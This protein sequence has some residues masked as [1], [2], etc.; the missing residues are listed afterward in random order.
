MVLSPDL[1]LLIAA[2]LGFLVTAGLKDLSSWLGTDFS[3]LAS[4]ITAT[5]VTLA[6]ALSNALLSMVPAQ[7]QPVVATVMTLIV[8]VFAAF[9]I[10]GTI[11]S[12]RPQ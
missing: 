4:A 8:A 12:L 9:G 11:K 2:G 6:V 1:Q 10:H 7:Y 5:L 3:S